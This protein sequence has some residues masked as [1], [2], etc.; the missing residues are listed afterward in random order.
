MWC[1]LV[2][3]ENSVYTLHSD[4]WQFVVLE[5]IK[6]RNKRKTAKFGT[7][8]YSIM[9]LLD[10]ELQM[11]LKSLNL[12]TIGMS[13]SNKFGYVWARYMMFP[14]LESLTYHLSNRVTNSIF[15]FL[16]PR[17]ILLE[18]V[19][20]KKNTCLI[21]PKC[22]TDLEDCLPRLGTHLLVNHQ[23]DNSLVIK[24]ATSSATT[25]LDVLTGRQLLGTARVYS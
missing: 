6:W 19:S 12:S 7:A 3:W 17:L 18:H 23:D 9:C 21:L 15:L 5:S 4:F 14:P 10:C 25:H 1:V 20:L 16:D 22:P 24:T 2:N 8:T 13:V 11:F